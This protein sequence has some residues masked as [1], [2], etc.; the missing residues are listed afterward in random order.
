LQRFRPRETLTPQMLREIN[1]GLYT[2]SRRELRDLGE[3]TGGRV[4]P[5][6]S[7]TDLTGV[8]KQVADDLRSQYSIGYYPANKARD[9]G[10]RSI[11]VETRAR[12]ATVRARSGYWAK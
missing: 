9:G 3:R 4:Y 11:R 10:W 6:R 7:L 1:A 5:V 12:D 2:L 8:Y